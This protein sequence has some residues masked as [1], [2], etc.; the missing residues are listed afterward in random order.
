MIDSFKIPYAK[1]YF[2]QTSEQY[3]L[4]TFQSSTISGSGVES[5]N[6][7]SLLAKKLDVLAVSLV[8]NGSAAIRLAY[9][10]LGVR[11]GTRVIL[12][13]WGFHVAAN[14]AYS[15]GADIEFRDVS[16]DTWCM[17]LEDNLD[18]AA[19]DFRGVLVLIHT[20]GNSTNL[21]RSQQFK[22]NTNLKIIEDSAEAL[23]SKYGENY[24]GTTF[25]I[26]TFSLHAAKTL[27]SGEG[28]FLVTDKSDLVTKI[29]LLRNHGMDPQNP[30]MHILAGDN[31]RLSNLLAS[32]VLP[33]LAS[34]DFIVGERLRV[35][36]AYK[37]LLGHSKEIRFL[38]ENDP[39][40]FFPWGVAIRLPG[41][42]IEDIG[43]L[44]LK[45]AKNG[46]DTRPGFTSAEKLPYYHESKSYLD[47]G[48]TNSNQLSNETLILPHYP[49]LTEENIAYI[50]DIIADSLK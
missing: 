13:G 9:Q 12:P 31:Y 10:A 5:R 17:E 39:N 45:L 23:F 19:E 50:C 47:R 11:P 34:L 7:E 8:S 2:P 1:P 40:G 44:R 48:L 33:Q 41:A 42:K 46:V 24:L 22:N 28:G 21:D 29:Q 35:Y 25:D 49:E 16:I 4:K 32:L 26:G 14:I 18:L 37:K 15:M 3:L 36:Q 20:L 27:T 30:Y 6:L 38:N 43:N